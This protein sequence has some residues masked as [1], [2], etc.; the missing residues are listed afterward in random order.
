MIEA[1]TH[2]LERLSALLAIKEVEVDWLILFVG[3]L[4]DLF[5]DAFE[6]EDVIALVLGTKAFAER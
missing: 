1:S 6:V 2:V 3:L 5:L 4:L